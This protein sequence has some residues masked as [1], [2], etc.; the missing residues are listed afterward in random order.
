[1][2]DLTLFRDRT[3]TLAIV[4]IFT[5]LFAIYGMLLVITQLFQNVRAY[6]PTQAGLLLLPYSLLETI[7]ALKV[8]KLVSVVGSRRLILFGLSSQIVGFAVI[9]AGMGSGTLVIV[10]GLLFAGL[11]VATCLT[12]ITALAMTAVPPERA[13]MASGIMS[14]QRALGSTVGFAVLGSVLAAFLTTTLGEHLAQALPDPVE[15]K[16]VV[17]TIIGNANPRAYAAEIG[18]GRPIQHVDSATQAAILTAADSDFVAGIRMSLATAILVLAIVLAAGY[19][20]F[21]RDK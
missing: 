15:R 12:P 6:S 5:V 18:P 4:T 13:G 14:A 7:V 3:Y 1:M 2:M 9:I 17:D 10:I 8:G 21:P 19:A 20:W 16:E 11:G